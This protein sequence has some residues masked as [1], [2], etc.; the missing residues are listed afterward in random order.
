[1]AVNEQICKA[2]PPDTAATAPP[3]APP[4]TKKL[5]ALHAGRR[6]VRRRGRPAHHVDGRHVGLRRGPGDRGDGDPHCERRGILPRGE[7]VGQ[8]GEPD[9]GLGGLAFGPTALSSAPSMAF[10]LNNGGSA[11]PAPHP[12]GAGPLSTP[13]ASRHATD[14][15]VAPP[16]RALLTLRLIPSMARGTSQV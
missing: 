1:M 7:P 12:N 3:A 4:G 2:R 9:A 16:E 10:A 15:S 6:R 11:L 8:L 14:R 13:Q 5:G